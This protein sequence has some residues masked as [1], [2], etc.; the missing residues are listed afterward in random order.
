MRKENTPW[1]RKDIRQDGCPAILPFRKE[2][3][4]LLKDARFS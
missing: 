1:G 3:A 4:F 2:G